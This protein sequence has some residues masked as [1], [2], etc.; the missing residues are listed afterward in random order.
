MV[1]RYLQKQQQEPEWRQVSGVAVIAA[2]QADSEIATALREQ[3]KTVNFKTKLIGENEMQN[4]QRM[5]MILVNAAV[6]IPI[7]SANSTSLSNIIKIGY[8]E[9][10]R[11]KNS[12]NKD[13]FMM[14]LLASPNDN[15]V[16]VCEE[17]RLHINNADM[18]LDNTGLKRIYQNLCTHEER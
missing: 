16:E 6:F 5:E 11:R 9:N 3:L 7:I 10:L 4:P 12:L 8:E 1:E 2:D 17:N 15:I 13:Y 18:P 14:P